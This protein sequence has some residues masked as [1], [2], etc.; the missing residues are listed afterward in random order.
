MQGFAL[1][2]DNPADGQLLGFNAAD[3]VWL[4]V[5]PAAGGGLAVTRPIQNPYSI[6]A[7]GWVEIDINFGATGAGPFEKQE[8]RVTRGYNK[9]QARLPYTDELGGLRLQFDG[10][11]V[12][13][14]YIV[15]LTPVVDAGQE[16]ANGVPML[17][18]SGF[19]PTKG[20][21]PGGVGV[22]IRSPGDDI[23]QTVRFMV[24]ISQFTP[25]RLG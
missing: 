22:V 11:D 8:A 4:P 13:A 20:R 15:K 5:D 3:K 14:S 16:R 6:V 25:D 2:A 7:A 17:F 12:E 1:K 23:F 19:F 10:F 24:E 18:C 21:V 9:L